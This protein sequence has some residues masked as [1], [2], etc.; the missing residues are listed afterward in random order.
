M[1]Y[2]FRRLCGNLAEPT[3]RGQ[4]HPQSV[5]TALRERQRVELNREVCLGFVWCCLDRFGI[6]RVGR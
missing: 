4:Q 2:H 6:E 1:R 3:G 5:D